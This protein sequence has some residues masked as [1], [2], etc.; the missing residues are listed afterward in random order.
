[1]I[2]RDRKEQED[3][4][5]EPT[6]VRRKKLKKI[7]FGYHSPSQHHGDLQDYI[8]ITND[9]LGSEAIGRVCGYGAYGTLP[10]RGRAEF[11]VKIV[12][13]RAPSFEIGLMRFEKKNA[14]ECITHYD[15]RRFCDINCRHQCY[16]D[17]LLEAFYM[18]GLYHNLCE[19]DRFGLRLSEDG[20]LELTVNGEGQGVAAENVY[21]R[22]TD[23]YV[24]VHHY[25]NS[26]ATV[27]TKA[28]EMISNRHMGVAVVSIFFIIACIT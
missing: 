20:V 1:M 2:A 18:D 9:G 16:L 5:S 10:L 21:S 25:F 4:S 12:K 6:P 8:R 19:G 13:S 7:Q 3:T 11:E 24:V 26:A 23:V 15:L 22:D 14:P 17:N 27:I 28:G